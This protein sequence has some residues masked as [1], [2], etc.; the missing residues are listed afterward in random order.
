MLIFEVFDWVYFNILPILTTQNTLEDRSRKLELKKFGPY[1]VKYLHS[2]TVVVGKESPLNTISANLVSTAR[3]AIEGTE[4]SIGDQ[5]TDVTETEDQER[6]DKHS[7][8]GDHLADMLVRHVE[9]DGEAKQVARWYDRS[10][11]HDDL[12]REEQN[13]LHFMD[14]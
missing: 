12:D 4:A 2:H 7:S 11:K 14:G 10:P 8:Q 13:H 3:L 1:C 9:E 6:A 5:I